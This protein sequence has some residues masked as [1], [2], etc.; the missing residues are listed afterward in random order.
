ML[1]GRIE[2]SQS[3]QFFVLEQDY[4]VHDS[5]G[6][7]EINLS[8]S[9]SGISVWLNESLITQTSIEEYCFLDT[10]TSGLSGG[11]G[12]YAFLIGAGRFLDGK[13]HLSQFFMRDPSE[14]FAQLMA[15]D[16]FLGS[17]KILVTFNGKAFD[18][19]LLNT[20]YM[21]QGSQPL[22][23]N[24]IQIDLLHLAR[25]MWRN[26]LTS[27]SLGNLEAEILG[28]NRSSDEV[29]GWMIPQLYFDYLHSGD[30]RPMKNVFYHNAIDILSMVT[31][32]NRIA[33]LINKPLDIQ[34]IHKNELAALGNIY[35]DLG[36]SDL[37]AQ[38]YELSLQDSDWDDN[39]WNTLQRLSYLHKKLENFQSAIVLWEKAAL[40]GHIY[41]HI[42]LA[43]YF[44]HRI[45][46][47]SIA[48]EWTHRALDLIDSPRGKYLD[49]VTWFEELNHRLERL[50]HKKER[51]SKE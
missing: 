31:L 15:L 13:F 20:R 37:A 40:H 29:P 19:P 1:P 7:H 3:G 41:A 28:V 39:D 48:I 36:E 44:E 45:L 24:F 23:K 12:T 21:M 4:P 2:Y 27:R 22:I 26:H 32:L 51:Y 5:H 10:E 14:E 18:V 30:A 43:K 25:R 17:T 33:E 35:E 50:M 47:Y 46:D 42:E 49:R 38:L 8:S 11:T 6:N 9:L 34:N 16:A